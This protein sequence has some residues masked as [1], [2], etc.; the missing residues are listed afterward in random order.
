VALTLSRDR[1]PHDPGSQGTARTARPPSHLVLAR[2]GRGSGFRN[3]P[4]PAPAARGA[5]GLPGS[6]PR[7]DGRGGHGIGDRR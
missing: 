5:A 1:S 7:G 2:R 4:G 6:D 3:V